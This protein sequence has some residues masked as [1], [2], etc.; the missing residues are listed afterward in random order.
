LLF[1]SVQFA[2]TSIACVTLL[3]I[4]VELVKVPPH[5]P[6]VKLYPVSV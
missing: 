5:V 3:Q 1:V 2:V 4:P 6:D